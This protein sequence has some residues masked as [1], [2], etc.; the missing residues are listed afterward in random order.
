[1]KKITDQKDW[2]QV[3]KLFPEMNDVYF[4][5]EYFKIFAEH[6]NVKFEGFFWENQHLSIFWSHLV[7]EIQNISDNSDQFFDLIT[8]YGYGGPLIH[9]KSKIVSRIKDSLHLFME[10]YYKFAREQNYICEFVRFHPILKNWELF[11]EGFQ[12]QI[13]LQYNNDTV[14]IDLSNDLDNIWKEI[15]KGHK[16]NINKTDKENC[17]IILSET[18]LDCDIEAFISLYYDTME[19]NC[20]SDKYFFTSSFIKDHFSH[21][22]SLLIAV[23]CSDQLLGASMFITGNSIVN[24]HLSGSRKNIKGVYPSDFIIWSAIKWAK[25]HNFS[26]LN[27]GGGFGKNDSLFNF[28]KGFSKTIAPYY[29]GKIIF[30][31]EQYEKLSKKCNQQD[32]QEK[33]FPLYRSGQHQ[34]I[35]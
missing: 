22:F 18:P 1:M 30:N 33:F 19:K 7:R 10:D 17:K 12:R 32:S 16:Y 11:S 21:L 6:Y 3:L 35:I 31:V 27:L 34:A 14:Y 24:Y 20:A 2:N 4:S 8:P 26:Y 29:T 25:N 23:E 13:L 9:C 5:Y 28:K 15:G